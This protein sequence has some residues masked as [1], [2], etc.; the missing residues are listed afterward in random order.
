MSGPGGASGFNP[1][2]T[3][4][5]HLTASG[6]IEI[7][8][9]KSNTNLI[10]TGSAY[11]NYS[12]S[13]SQVGSTGTDF[14]QPAL[15]ISG[16]HPCLLLESQPQAETGTEPSG[17]AVLV[18]KDSGGTGAGGSN[19]YYLAAL[20]SNDDLVWILGDGGHSGTTIYLQNNT[21][22]GGIGL[23]TTAS[24]GGPIFFA[25]KASTALCLNDDASAV[26]SGSVTIE[27]QTTLKVKTTYLEGN[28]DLASVATAL[29]WSGAMIAMDQNGG[30]R[31]ITLPTATTSAEATAIAGWYIE[32]FN[33][34]AG[35][36]ACTIVRGDTS[37]DFLQGSVAAHGQDGLSGLTIGSNVVTFASGDSVEGDYVKV[38]CYSA[39]A[40]NT[41]FI[42]TGAS[43]T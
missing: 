32:V 4:T 23:Y 6:G 2:N 30:S 24:T 9:D 11:I 5:S 20:D 12:S 29:G 27:G 22:N 10:V 26:F 15:H 41:Y 3:S 14:D 28:L 13:V 31:T 38:L 37:N 40:S 33:A 1:S 18:L 34:Y 25:P 36:N 8:G 35:S 42:A 43:N 19:R 17:D 39:D 7:R 21:A 16:G